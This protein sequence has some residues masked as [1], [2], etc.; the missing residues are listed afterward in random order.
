MSTLFVHY[1]DICTSTQTK[2]TTERRNN[3]SHLCTKEPSA[4]KRVD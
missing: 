2:L 4:V 1:D 3:K